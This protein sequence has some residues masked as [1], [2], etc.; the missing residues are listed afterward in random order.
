MIVIMKMDELRQQATQIINKMSNEDLAAFMPLLQNMDKK[1]KENNR[2]EFL[3][4][5]KE[6]QS[7]AASVGYT[8]NDIPE[9]IKNVRRNRKVCV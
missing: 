2:R 9:I 6:L 7:W 3:A 5:A 1:R 4:Y 8:E